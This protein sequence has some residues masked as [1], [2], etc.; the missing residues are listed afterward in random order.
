MQPHAVS[1]R[2]HARARG[3]KAHLDLDRTPPCVPDP[4]RA[5]VRRRL[6]RERRANGRASHDHHRPAKLAIIHPV[7]P[8][9]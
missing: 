1:P 3:Y 2:A 8:L 5:R 9:G 4:T 7:R 6:P